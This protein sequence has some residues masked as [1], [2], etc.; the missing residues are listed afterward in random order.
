MPLYF[1]TVSNA[2][3]TNTD[4]DGIDLP[5]LESAWIEATKSTG[6]LLREINHAVAPGAVLRMDVTDD[7]RKPLLSLRVIA[8]QHE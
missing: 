2:D 1:F 8:E 3:R 4:H 6:E 7:T 5:D